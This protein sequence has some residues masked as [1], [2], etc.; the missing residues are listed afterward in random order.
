MSYSQRAA[1]F[2]YASLLVGL[3]RTPLEFA[4]SVLLFLAAIPFLA[5]IGLLAWQIS[6]GKNWAR[7]TF[8]VLF[9]LGLPFAILPLAEAL[10]SRPLSGILGILQLALQTGAV[11]LLFLPGGHSRFDR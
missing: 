9:A 6:C 8:T 3:V 10:Q 7:I 1:W 4:P 5:L 2:I 11:V